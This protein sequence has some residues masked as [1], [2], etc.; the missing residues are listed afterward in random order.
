MLY[1]EIL[2]YNLIALNNPFDDE[3]Q[4]CYKSNQDWYHQLVFL[5]FDDIIECLYC[6][7]IEA[8]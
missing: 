4:L 6:L 2:L 3:I 1:L 7:L 5:L 8:F